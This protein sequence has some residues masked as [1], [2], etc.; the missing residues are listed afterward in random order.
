MQQVV[1]ID[2]DNQSAIFLVKNLAYHGE[3][4]HI[5]IQYQFVRD[6]MGKKKVLLEKVDTVNNVENSMTK[7]MRKEKFT[8]CF[9]NL[10]MEMERFP[11]STKNTKSGRILGVIFLVGRL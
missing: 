11:I 2:F 5:D 1:R 7:S 8:W 9:P 6:V 4:K 10:V 3:T